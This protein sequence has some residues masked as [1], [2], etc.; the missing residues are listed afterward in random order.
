[1]MLILWGKL[2]PVNSDPARPSTNLV[3]TRAG[4]DS[5]IYLVRFDQSG[6]FAEHAVRYSLLP[7]S[8]LL[9]LSE[10]SL[11]GGGHDMNPLIFSANSSGSW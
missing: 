5:T 7:V 1:M 9:F 6:A 11:V 10:K 2:T 8:S 3:Q 4:Q